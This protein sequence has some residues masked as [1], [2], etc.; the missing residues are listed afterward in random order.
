MSVVLNEVAHARQAA[1]RPREFVAVESPVLCEAQREVAVA[2]CLCL[3]DDGALRTIHRLQ[4]ELLTFRLNDE[5]I[6][7]VE[8]PVARL[9]PEALA[10]NDRRGDLLIAARVLQIAHRALERAPEELPLRMPEG[11]TRRNVM[12]GEEVERHT[13]SSVV[14]LL[15]LIAT[16]DELVKLL[17]RV[18]GGPVDAL[19]HWSVALST[20]VRTSNGE[21]L[22]RA[23]LASALHM[24]PTTEILEFAVRVGGDV[25]LRLAGRCSLGGE[26]IHDL[27]LERL[28]KFHEL[29]ARIIKCVLVQLEGVIRG[30]ALRHLSFD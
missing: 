9:L 15:H 6:L 5:H 7:A 10:D 12:E 24:R 4:A 17:L 21:E 26:I 18:P 27:D 22:I 20:P 1:Q 13:E 3:I 25:R 16:P 23:D 8:L 2:A 29:R 30:D 19:Q 14:T 28:I 11:A